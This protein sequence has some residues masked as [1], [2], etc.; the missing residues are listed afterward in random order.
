MFLL[1][2]SSAESAWML[3]GFCASSGNA[4]APRPI[5]SNAATASERVDSARRFARRTLEL[6]RKNNGMNPL[7]FDRRKLE[8]TGAQITGQPDREAASRG[9]VDDNRLVRLGELTIRID[10]QRWTRDL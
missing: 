10:V 7:R 1:W 3:I 5:S 4:H 9:G 8:K 6:V 2:S